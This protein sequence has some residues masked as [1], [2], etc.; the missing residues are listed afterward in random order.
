MIQGVI[1]MKLI[2]AMTNRDSVL[3]EVRDCILTNDEQRCKKLC[4]QIHG[5]WK[6]LS[7]HNGCIL[8]DKKLAIPHV[9]KE[10]VMDILHATH[11]GAW[12]MTELGQR[13]WWPYINRDLI[14][15]SKTCRPCTEFG[16]NL[17]SLIP[18]T[19]WAPSHDAQN[20]MK[21][22]KSVSVVQS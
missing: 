7:T 20:L 18:K 19:K 21:K 8:V 16:K 22:Y 11:P 12:G 4:K 14:N 9:M 3:R 1:N 6:N 17:K 10:P 2:A 13:L 15:K 5:Q